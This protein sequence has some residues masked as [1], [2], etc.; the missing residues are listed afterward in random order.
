[1]SKMQEYYDQRFASS[2]DS[3]SIYEPMAPLVQAAHMFRME[4]LDRLPIGDL[5][6]K[7][8]VD[9]GTGSWGFACIFPRLHRCKRAIGIDISAEAVKMS[10]EVSA[11]GDFAYGANVEY[12]VSDGIEI[13]LASGSVDVFFTG[14]CI[15][16]VE[17]TDAFLDE[18]YRVLARNGILVLTTP[19]PDALIYRALGDTYA[20][21]PEHIALMGYD[22]LSAY[23]VPRFSAV[24]SK[25]YNGSMHTI[26]DGGIEDID[27]AR[28]WARAFEDN[29]RD[30]CGI[31]MMMQKRDGHS[32]RK[33]LRR[34]YQ[35]SDPAIRY[36]GERRE[37]PLHGSLTGSMIQSGAGVSLK[38]AGKELIALLW[39]HAWSGYAALQID[40]RIELVDCYSYAGGFKRVILRGLDG[41]SDHQF[42]LR[43]TGERN[44][45]SAGD[46]VILHSL[47]VYTTA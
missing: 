31:V 7:T 38:F 3:G 24:M 28:R 21:G 8:V 37:L 45:R 43:A 39:A 16:H 41:A 2:R 20:V 10:A 15:E 29:P 12:Y 25:G 14:E 35:H 44:A 13:P 46:Q 22:E 32:P 33:F 1:M 40:E 17:N 18:I 19:N 9:F 36:F 26:L 5:H 11:N 23:L 42:M 27:F 34:T 30:A 4:L 47:S 6:D